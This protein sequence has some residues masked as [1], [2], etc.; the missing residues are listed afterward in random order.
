ML[1]T[2][3]TLKNFNCNCRPLLMGSSIVDRVPEAYGSAKKLLMCLQ[4]D[5]HLLWSSFIF[6]LMFWPELEPYERL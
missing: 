3:S 4:C 1:A 6:S 5:Q 2:N